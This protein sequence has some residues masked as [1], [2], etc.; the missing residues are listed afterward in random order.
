MDAA[1]DRLLSKL[2][3]WSVGDGR[4][5]PYYWFWGSDA[6]RQVGGERWRRWRRALEAAAVPNQRR[7]EQ[8]EGAAGSWDPVG[9][10]GEVGGRVCATALVTLALESSYRRIPGRR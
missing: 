9:P 4:A 10:W 1:A 5:D 7:P 8:G 3:V 2:P 6:M